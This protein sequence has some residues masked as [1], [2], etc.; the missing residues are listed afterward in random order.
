M[1]H[2]PEHCIPSCRA[3]GVGP[4]KEGAGVHG[5]VPRLGGAKT[6][7][8][9]GKFNREGYRCVKSAN[10]KMWEEEGSGECGD[11][12]KILRMVFDRPSGTIELVGRKQSAPSSERRANAPKNRK[13]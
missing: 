2:L 1:H 5:A 3:G 4:R 13:K 8:N 9:V 12:V 7:R 6:L 10:G 11:R